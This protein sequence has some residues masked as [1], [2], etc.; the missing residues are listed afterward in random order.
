MNYSDDEIAFLANSE[1]RVALLEALRQGP[2]SRDVLEDR[3]GVSRVTLAR[4]LDE[5]AERHWIEQRGQVAEITPLGAWVVGEYLA[6]RDTMDAERRLRDVVKWFPN[7]PYGFHISELADAEITAVSRANASAPLSKHVQ[8]FEDGGEFWS[9]S[10]AITRLFLETCWRRVLD[11]EVT[12]DWVF[13]P[14]VLDVLADD[15]R[16][17][18]QSR[19]MLESG[20]ARFRVYDGEIPY[21]VLGSERSIHL[22]LADEDG[23]PTALVQTDAEAVREW[24]RTT[25]STY[26]DGGRSIGPETFDA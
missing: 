14:Q 25:F 13:T 10:F 12:F 19:D 4:I 23:S 17:A 6:F 2:H 22:R 5:L 8:Q 7:E 24:T 21:I 3:I 16:M 9:F 1:N 15:D 20:G 18:S 26:W 11:G